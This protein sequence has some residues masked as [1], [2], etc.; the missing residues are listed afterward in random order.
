MKYAFLNVFYIVS[1][2]AWK[3]LMDSAKHA[4]RDEGINIALKRIKTGWD[5]KLGFVIGLRVEVASMAEY[6]EEILRSME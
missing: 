6:N 2:A 4:F 1:T 3:S 5:S